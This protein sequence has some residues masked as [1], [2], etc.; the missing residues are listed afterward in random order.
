MD[1]TSEKWNPFLFRM[2]K[3][4]KKIRDINAFD[5]LFIKNLFMRFYI[6]RQIR[7]VVIL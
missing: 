4:T 1:Q 5:P 3:I 7:H 2:S 6:H